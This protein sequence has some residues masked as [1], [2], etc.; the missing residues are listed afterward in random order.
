[1]LI[2]GGVGCNKRLK[3]MMSDVVR[4]IEETQYAPWITDIVLIMGP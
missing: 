1:M 3:E 4:E 2:V